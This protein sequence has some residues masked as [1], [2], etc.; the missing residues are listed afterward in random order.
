MFQDDYIMRQIET[1]TKALARVIFHKEEDTTEVIDQDGNLSGSNLL[2][3]RLKR[4]L[5]DGR[6]NEA[7]NLLYEAIEQNP[8]DE[9]FKTALAFYDELKN[10][11]DEKLKKCNYSREEIYDGLAHIN[12]TW[13]ASHPKGE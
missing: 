10:W 2:L 3:Y 6:V 4:M 1:I 11:N 13:N 9:Y 7:E 8:Q 12:R 5:H